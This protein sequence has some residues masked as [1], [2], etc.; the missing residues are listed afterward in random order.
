MENA[1]EAL[2]IGFAIFVFALGTVLLFRVGSVARDV[3]AEMVAEADKTTY[4][5]YYKGDE[6]KLADDGNRIVTLEQMIPAIYRYSTESCGV[7]IIDKRESGTPIVARFDMETELFCN[8]WNGRNDSQKR[9][10]IKSLNYYV[11]NPVGADPLG[12][13]DDLKS[14]FQKIYKQDVTGT[15]TSDFGCHWTGRDEYKA[16]R[17]DSDLSRN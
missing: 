4:Y 5:T 16:Q 8:S 12:E 7:T 6:F 17:I 15:R 10:L 3:S 13:I 9:E 1:S 2:K 14:L 11:L